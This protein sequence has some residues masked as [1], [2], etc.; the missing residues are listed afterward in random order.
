MRH[1]GVLTSR[2]GP[3]RRLCCYVGSTRYP[4]DVRCKKHMGDYQRWLA[5]PSGKHCTSVRV[6]AAGEPIMMLLERWPCLS[7][8]GLFNRE[9][10]WLRRMR[11]AGYD[12]VNLHMPGAIAHAGGPKRYASIKAM[13]HYRRNS[14]KINQKRRQK[15]V[16]ECG[17]RFTICNKAQ[18]AKTEKHRAW[19][20]GQC[21]GQQ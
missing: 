3:K 10:H 8:T 21:A 1:V 13:E 12:C 18:H 4:L 16:C 20:A 19:V 11:H 15:C 17:G 6:C 7:R 2:P 9:G 14:V 5:D